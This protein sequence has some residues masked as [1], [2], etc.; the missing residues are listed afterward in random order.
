MKIY[1]DKNLFIMMVDEEAN[2][3]FLLNIDDGSIIGLRHKPIQQLPSTYVKEISNYK[4][5][6]NL[7]FQY[8]QLCL[9][10]HIALEK[11]FL[12]FLDKIDSLKDEYITT[13]VKEILYS[14]RRILYILINDWSFKEVITCLKSFEADDIDSCQIYE[15]IRM[16]QWKKQYKFTDLSYDEMSSLLISSKL[17]TL[18]QLDIQIYEYYLKT[19]QMN[20]L[21]CR[22]LIIHYLYQCHELNIK[23]R[24]NNNPIREFAETQKRFSAWKEA[25]E[26]ERFRAQY[27]KKPNA[28][29]F[30]YGDFM[31]CIPNEGKDLVVEGAKMH[32][33]VGNYVNEITEGKTYICFVRRKDNP[34]RPYITCQVYL[35]GTIGQYYLAYD[36]EISSDEDIAFKRAYQQYLHSVW[37][38]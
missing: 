30:E 35:D 26:R 4:G 19:Q 23:P 25:T 22:N 9:K 10:L 24:K 6:N 17:K 28:W 21:D 29:E 12:S 27:I 38:K 11:N 1:K 14:D 16:H 7:A 15:N 36:K 2:K 32:H 13:I 18:T 5:I 37:N 31:I 3:Y 34:T 8:F 33:C 20:V